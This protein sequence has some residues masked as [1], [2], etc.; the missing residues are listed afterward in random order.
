MTDEKKNYNNTKTVK[1]PV[2]EELTVC[3][4]AKWKLDGA[5]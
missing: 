3:D 4:S 5:T 2:S 1:R